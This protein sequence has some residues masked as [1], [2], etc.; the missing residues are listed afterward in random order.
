[1]KVKDLLSHITGYSKIDKV[2]LLHHG[3]RFASI[4]FSDLVWNQRKTEYDKDRVYSFAILDGV[5]RLHVE[6]A[7]CED[8]EQA[9]TVVT[10]T[11][12]PRGGRMT[13]TETVR[14]INQ[15]QADHVLEMVAENDRAALVSVKTE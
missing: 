9:R 4:P 3:Y 12:T 2:E 11:Y 14:C 5:L 1:M 8:P 10:Y 6:H 13:F 15:I 7:A